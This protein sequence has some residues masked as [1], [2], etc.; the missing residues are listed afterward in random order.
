MELRFQDWFANILGVQSVAQ[1]GA[2]QPQTQDE[3]H[4]PNVDCNAFINSLPSSYA[5]QSIAHIKD[6]LAVIPD[7]WNGGNISTN[8]L[9]DFMLTY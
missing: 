1:F 8:S 6:N 3:V 9:K 4:D 5:G 7:D 2:K